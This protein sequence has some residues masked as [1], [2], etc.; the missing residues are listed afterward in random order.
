MQFLSNE[1]R[2]G[3]EEVVYAFPV[4]SELLSMEQEWGLMD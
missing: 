1:A 4:Q 2:S 3:F